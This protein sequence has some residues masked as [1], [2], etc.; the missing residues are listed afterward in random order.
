MVHYQ[1]F[2]T[3]LLLSPL[4]EKIIIF[5]FFRCI[6]SQY[7]SNFNVNHMG[8]L[9]KCSADSESVSLEQEL[10]FC[11]SKTF[12]GT[13]VQLVHGTHLLSTEH[14]ILPP[15]DLPSHTPNLFLGDFSFWITDF[16]SSH[17]TESVPMI[18]LS[19]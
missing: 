2:Q 3:L 11:I 4:K 12:S 8:F 16:L 14:C 13:P 9:L 17:L 7:V 18:S 15:A 19:T 5:G 10:R 1:S 6:L